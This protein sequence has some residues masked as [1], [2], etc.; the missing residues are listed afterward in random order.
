[1]YTEASKPPWQAYDYPTVITL[2]DQL[3]QKKYNWKH[4]PEVLQNPYLFSAGDG[5]V[6]DLLKTNTESSCIVPKFLMDQERAKSFWVN[7][8]KYADLARYILEFIHDKWVYNLYTLRCANMNTWI[9]S[10]GFTDIVDVHAL[11]PLEKLD[12]S[13]YEVGKLAF[14]L[15]PILLSKIEALGGKV[16]EFRAFLRSHLPFYL[17]ENDPLESEKVKATQAIEEFLKVW[18]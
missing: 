10:R 15:L 16:D 9:H 2:L 8:Q 3:N 5:K 6:M 4:I 1:M 11:V 17:M 13:Y 12:T 7:S 18:F 14:D